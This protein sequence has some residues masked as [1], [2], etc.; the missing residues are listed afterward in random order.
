MKKK[1]FNE[2]ERK[3]LFFPEFANHSK[4]RIPLL[5]KMT[6]NTSSWSVKENFNKAKLKFVIPDFSDLVGKTQER[7]TASSR[8]SVMLEGANL[9]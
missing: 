3:V 6:L 7:E 2:W 1:T 8:S 4:K 9:L 5:P